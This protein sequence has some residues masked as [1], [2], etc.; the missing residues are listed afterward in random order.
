M[1][2]KVIMAIDELVKEIYTL[3][4][5][6]LN[7]KFLN[8]IDSMDEFI[9]RMGEQGYLVDLTVELNSIQNA[10]MKKDFVQLSDYLLYQLKPQFEGLLE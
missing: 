10:F 1:Q 5:A 7:Q 8:M 3:E 4:Q 2:K 9:Q 6:D